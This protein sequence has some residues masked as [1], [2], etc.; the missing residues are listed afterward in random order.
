M[1][2]TT[3]NRFQ[4]ENDRNNNFLRQ[5]TQTMSAILGGCDVVTILPLKGKTTDEHELN[6][7]MAKNIP[8]ILR[9]ESY[10]D[11]VVDPAAG[12][13]FIED[14]T[15]QLIE[16]S[17]N[18]F[19]EIENKGGLI[20]CI[21]SNFIQNLIE[22]N[23]QHLLSQI[24]SKKQTFLGINKYPNSL[25]KW[26]AVSPAEKLSG[27]DFKPLAPFNLEQQYQPKTLVS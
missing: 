13:M 7:R 25:E 14:L 26:I 3:S 22:E 10:F 15:N 12:S 4:A 5:T 6:E 11:K 27:A 17:W 24:E 16:K 20:S 2:A 1:Y 23:Q 18:L 8:L 19:K 9:E 21:E